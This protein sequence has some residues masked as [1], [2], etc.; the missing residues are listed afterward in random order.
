[1]LINLD[2]SKNKP[3]D[4]LLLDD[5]AVDFDFS[6][7][8]HKRLNLNKINIRC[9]FKTIL[10]WTIRSEKSLG[11]KEIYKRNLY[12]SFHPK[13]IISHHINK[14]S[15]ESKYLCPEIISM[16]Y[17][18]GFVT[19][20]AK[21]LKDLESKNS[22]CDYFFVFHEKD[23]NTLCKYFNSNFIISGSVRN[24]EMILNE[25]KTKDNFITYISEFKN[26]PKNL[27]PEKY[28]Y[29]KFVYNYQTKSE[30]IILNILAE[31]CK[32][33]KKKL[34]IA[35]RSN[36]S[37]KNYK[38]K[39]IDEIKYYEELIGDKFKYFDLNSYEVAQNSELTVCIGSNLGIELLS[40]NFK[41][42]FIPF[43]GNYNKA[44]IYPY[45]DNLNCPF[46][47]NQNEKDLIVK[48]LN[49]LINLNIDEWKKIIKT[50]AKQIMFDPQ[51]LILKN[52]I[53]EILT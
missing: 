1:M 14:R 47:H 7:F 35:L 52:K 5:G 10:N 38:I 17:Q 44:Q 43:F 11:L 39:K 28:K 9:F 36:R 29:Q 27:N 46:I 4:I 21:Y 32:K 48:K 6:E 37:D 49:N 42:F 13:I 50:Y 16:T 20:H 18:F 40:R 51:N 31:F 23:K 15:F 53:K 24:N 25:K 33:N 8:K 34:T 45:F 12:R 26:K 19:E 41:V 3:T 30:Q 22:R 2:F